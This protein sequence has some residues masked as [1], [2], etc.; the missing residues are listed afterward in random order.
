MS[1]QSLVGLVVA[2]A[3]A[4]REVSTSISESREAILGF[5]DKKFPKAARSLRAN[6]V[7]KQLEN[8]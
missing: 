3:A 2:C 5:S 1:K 4:E 8:M 6:I 7:S